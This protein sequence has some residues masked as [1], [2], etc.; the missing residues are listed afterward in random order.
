MSMPS[1]DNDELKFFGCGCT[2]VVVAVLVGAGA[3][4]WALLY[5]K[6]AGTGML[7]TVLAAVVTGV[8]VGVLGVALMLLGEWRKGRRLTGRGK[9]LPDTRSLRNDS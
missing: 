5:D 8:V 7:L 1:P 6:G 9:P 4:I 2:T 3:G